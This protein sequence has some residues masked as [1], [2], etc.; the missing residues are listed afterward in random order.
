MFFIK[1]VDYIYLINLIVFDINQIRIKNSLVLH[2]WGPIWLS[3]FLYRI[4]PKFLVFPLS[5]FIENKF[6]FDLEL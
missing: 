1:L 6:R 5:L 2:N 4:V 3:L